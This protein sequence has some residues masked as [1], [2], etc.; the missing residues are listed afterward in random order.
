MED[1]YDF[2]G[3]VRRI[4][5]RAEERKNEKKKDGLF[6]RFEQPFT[7]WRDFK[8]LGQPYIPKANLALLLAPGDQKTI[9]GPEVLPVV[10]MFLNQLP[11]NFDMVYGWVDLYEIDENRIMF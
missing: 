1:E 7:P 6:E 9:N 3:F 4:N 11:R 2:E 10:K 5:R 8:L